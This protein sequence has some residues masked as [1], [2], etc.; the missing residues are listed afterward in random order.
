MLIVVSLRSLSSLLHTRG[1]EEKKM[2][3]AAVRDFCIAAKEVVAIKEAARTRSKSVLEQKKSAHAVLEELLTGCSPGDA[4]GGYLATTCNGSTYRVRLR[5]K[6]CTTPPK[7]AEAAAERVLELWNN[8]DALTDLLAQS[9][10]MDPSSVLVDYILS[11]TSKINQKTQVLEVTPYRPKAEQEIENAP[12]PAPA[13]SG[14]EE[15]LSSYVL[16][17]EEASSILRECKE[18]RK[19]L[20]ERWSDAE[21]RLIGE[22]D[23]L[24]AD[25]K[26]QKVNL[27]DSDGHAESYYLRVKP[28][29]KQSAKSLLGI[30]SYR[31][32]L[33]SAVDDV[34][35]RFC[36]DPFRA[37][38][39]V[40]RI[41]FGQALSDSLRRLVDEL[42]TSKTAEATALAATA[43]RR[44][45]L[46]RV[47]TRTRDQG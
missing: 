6:T 11:H 46:D 30:K 1:H 37:P 16:A 21:E 33:K 18:K 10:S 19:N 7:N 17:K 28:A 20:E 2:A 35:T 25:K 12:R 15:L 31:A 23:A 40:P 9:G 4:T 47:R 29:R 13:G 41:E 45:A 24:P 42:V 27:R 22:L 26:I 44:V 8:Q 39:I 43:P 32:V 3:S 38:S 36:A 34:I 5:P 14:I